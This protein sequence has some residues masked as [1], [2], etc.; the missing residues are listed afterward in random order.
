MRLK[1]SAA[2]QLL[3]LGVIIVLAMILGHFFQV[4]AT[5]FQ[6]WL[7]S[8][9]VGWFSMILFLGLYISL[10]SLI[11]IGPK[12]VLRITAALVYGAGVSTLLIWVGE[13]INVIIMFGLSRRLGRDFV[14][15]R[16]KGKMKQLDQAMSTTNFW[17]IFW[18]RFFPVVPFRFQDLGFGLTSVSLR[19]YF[20]IVMLA[21]PIRIF[22]LQFFLS[23]GPNV[24]QNPKVIEIYFNNHSEV[25]PLVGGYLVGSLILMFILSRKMH[26]V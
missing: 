22:F 12:D 14:A 24:I 6:Q 19:K 15:E 18:L 7:L 16:L 2:L 9:R 5:S 10:T 4:D 25:L 20:I 3:V 1:G 26:R 17:W 23:L 13:L 8:Y 11:W 21:S